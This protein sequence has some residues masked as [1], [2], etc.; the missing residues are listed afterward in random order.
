M[1]VPS[2]PAAPVSSG[3]AVADPAPFVFTRAVRSGGGETNALFL[4]Y[5]DGRKPRRVGKVEGFRPRIGK[6]WIVFT[7]ATSNVTRV[8]RDGRKVRLLTRDGTLFRKAYYTP[9]ISPDGRW[10]VAYQ[11]GTSRR[12]RRTDKL[13]I[14]D[15]RGKRKRQLPLPDA[16]AFSPSF[17]PDGRQIVLTTH[18][19]WWEQPGRENGPP[20]P[21]DYA[22]AVMDADGGNPRVLTPYVHDGI[23]DY[24][25]PAF[26]PDGE[27]I[28]Y[29]CG[30][31]ICV[32]D[33]QEGAA[34]RVLI[35]DVGSGEADD[36]GFTT[37][38]PTFS[39]DGRF[40]AFGCRR[41]YQ[42]ICVANADGSGVRVLTRGRAPSWN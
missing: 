27:S 4:G 24:A 25:D 38:H 13:W 2:A 3:A 17:S 29:G 31:G 14:M 41:N 10:V 37:S 42:R 6:R 19:A 21:P 1:L 11:V 32:V 8:R 33:A 16:Q 12:S 34:A 28:V 39:P 7:G 23:F 40:L 9:A 20:G 15:T 5:V 26:T 30:R 36:G 18:R 22:L 35:T